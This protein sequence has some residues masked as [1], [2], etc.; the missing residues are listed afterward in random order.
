MPK[1]PSDIFRRNATS[2]LDCTACVPGVQATKQE[3]KLN[4]AFLLLSETSNPCL[5][6]SHQVTEAS[7][8]DRKKRIIAIL[9]F[10]AK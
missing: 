5:E 4:T 9:R 8:L 10:T 7:G 2:G 1:R 6:D 3:C